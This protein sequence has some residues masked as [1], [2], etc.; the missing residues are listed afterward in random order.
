[1]TFVIE[2]NSEKKKRKGGVKDFLGVA[3]RA[4]D[5]GKGF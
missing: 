3:R 2:A 5:D 4:G 1:M